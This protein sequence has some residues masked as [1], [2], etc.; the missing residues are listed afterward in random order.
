MTPVETLPTPRPD[1]L[2]WH[3]CA[4]TWGVE[5]WGRGGVEA[6]R[7]G[8]EGVVGAGAP[9]GLQHRVGQQMV[10]HGTCPGGKRSRGSWE[11]LK[12]S[13]GGAQECPLTSVQG[14]GAV[15][16]AC[17]EGGFCLLPHGVV[18]HPPDSALGTQPSRE[19]PSGRPP[20]PGLM[21]TTR[22]PGREP[23][24]PLGSALSVGAPALP[25]YLGPCVVAG[26]APHR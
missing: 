9:T 1:T 20:S 17:H 10:P 7:L 13:A 26:V 22:D 2:S 25:A 6:H 3:Q 15:D 18:P 19:G 21:G 4:L 14:R 12:G 5:D 16:V 8:N 11:N 23:P 24:C